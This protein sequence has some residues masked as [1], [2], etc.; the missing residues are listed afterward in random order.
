[1]TM[2]LVTTVENRAFIDL[3]TI[4][5][6][7]GVTGRPF[8]V[9]KTPTVERQS[10]FGQLVTVTDLPDN[11]TDETWVGFYNDHDGDVATAIE[12]YRISL[13]A[14]PESTAKKTKKK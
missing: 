4:P 9:K 13:T 7:I 12:N 6:Q 11:A 2:L 8:I 3:T 5:A 14:P 1:M 10:T